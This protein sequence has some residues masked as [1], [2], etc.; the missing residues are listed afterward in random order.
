PFVV[1]GVHN[2]IDLADGTHC[3]ELRVS[4]ASIDPLHQPFHLIA[5][6]RQVPAEGDRRPDGS[7][8]C[9]ATALRWSRLSALESDDLFH[10]AARA[11]LDE[12]LSSE[13][14]VAIESLEFLISPWE[15]RQW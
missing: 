11:Q 7:A 1:T 9:A 2:R 3:G 10:Q 14:L 13:R 4:L 5:L 12:A 15:W 6:H 8:H